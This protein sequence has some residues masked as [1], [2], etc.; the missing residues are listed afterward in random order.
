M[1]PVDPA[2]E[3][4]HPP[5]P[6]PLWN[7]SYYLD[8][9][10]DDAA[11]GGYIRLGLYPNLGV[12]WYWACLVGP[13]RQLA[14]VIE[15]EA[16]VPEGESLELR[17]SGLWTDL[18]VET[19]LDHMTVGLEAFGVG[20]DDPLEAYGKMFG[21]RVPLGFELDWDTDGTPYRYPVAE[22]YE[23]PCL[24]HG[25]ILAGAEVIDFVGHGQRDHS[26]GVRDWWANSWT[27]LSARFDDGERIHGLDFDG[28][29]GVGYRQRVDG[30][31]EVDTVQSRP[32]L[33]PGGLAVTARMALGGLEIEITPLA[34]SPV[35]LTAPDGRLSRFPR[36]MI[37]IEDA[38]G[39]TGSGWVEYNQPQDPQ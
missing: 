16:P 24:V 33:G 19:P 30:F 3:R 1:V 5:G 18:I 29:F 7:E 14:T 2:D 17:A 26:W 13:D 21:D 8:F 38:A 22:R 27:W 4:R 6:E 28:V 10:S 35:L 15:P 31:T 39:R 20:L 9:V 25:E 23:I 36:A 34:W 37:R 32:E 12:S 11:V